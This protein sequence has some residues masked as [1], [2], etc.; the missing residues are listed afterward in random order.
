MWSKEVMRLGT[1]WK[2][3]SGVLIN[4]RRDPW[5]PTLSF[6]RITSNIS[7]DSNVIVDNLITEDNIWD[8]DKLCSRFLPFEVE[9]INRVPIAGS[10][11][12]DT[13]YWKWEKKGH[14]TTKSGY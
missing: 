2:V 7:Y 1:I 3:D 14:Y 8:G 10:D 11:Q 4:A 9:A 5:I 6:G 12:P 13:R